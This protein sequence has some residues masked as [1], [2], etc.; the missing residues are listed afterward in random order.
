MDN[1]FEL[2]Y[3]EEKKHYSMLRNWWI[4]WKKEP[5]EAKRLPQYGVLAKRDGIYYAALFLIRKENLSCELEYAI[6]NKDSLRTID[7]SEREEI[8]GLLASL[9]MG[10]AKKMGFEAIQC[11]ASTRYGNITKFLKKLG[12]REHKNQITLYSGRL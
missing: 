10:L 8:R 3:Y 9:L 2:E 1:N 4:D 11:N 5:I 12:F 7:K 6:S